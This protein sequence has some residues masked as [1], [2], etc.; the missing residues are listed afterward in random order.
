MANYFGNIRQQLTRAYAANKVVEYGLGRSSTK[1]GIERAGMHAF[2]HCHA[3]LLM[4]VD[5]H[6]SRG[7]SLL[8]LE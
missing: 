5:V 4:D 7:R 3:S 8:I 1:L 6:G 2:R